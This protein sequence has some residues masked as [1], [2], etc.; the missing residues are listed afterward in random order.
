[1]AIRFV[2]AI[3]C[4]PSCVMEEYDGH[5]P[6]D[7]CP[8]TEW[9]CWNITSEPLEAFKVQYIYSEQIKKRILF[10]PASNV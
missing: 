1:M 7:Q 6:D 3:F 9:L 2:A 4:D 8:V 5:Q 10:T